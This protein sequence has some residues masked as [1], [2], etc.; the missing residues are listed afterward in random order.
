[1]PSIAL[2]AAGGNDGFEAHERLSDQ[3]RLFV[4][5][6]DGDFELVVVGGVVDG[7]AQF[8]VPRIDR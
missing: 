7:E 2:A 4:V 6:E 8:L 1:M 5:V 3:L